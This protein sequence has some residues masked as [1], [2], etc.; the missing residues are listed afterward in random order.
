MTN[1]ADRPFSDIATSDRFQLVGAV[2]R[3]LNGYNNQIPDELASAFLEAVQEAG[4][5]GD[6]A[7]AS[8]I[9][10]AY[11]ADRAQGKLGYSACMRMSNLSS[12]DALVQREWLKVAAGKDF[13]SSIIDTMPACQ[14]L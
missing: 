4:R 9:A 14:P 5:E 6:C 2:I 3:A 12:R 1:T 10:I 8:Q 7:N 11:I 13:A